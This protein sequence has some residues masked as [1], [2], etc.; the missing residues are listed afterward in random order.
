MEGEP[1]LLNY[2]HCYTSI[3][4][5]VPKTQSYCPDTLSSP[6]SLAECPQM[7]GDCDWMALPVVN[8]LCLR[9]NVEI[10]EI[11]Q[12]GNIVEQ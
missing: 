7:T 8:P 1:I 11:I 10:W 5:K 2:K 12:N 9:E 6:A 3:V 4:L